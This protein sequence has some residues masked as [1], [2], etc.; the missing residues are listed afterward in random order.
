MSS[1]ICRS[2]CPLIKPIKKTAHAINYLESVKT[3]GCFDTMFSFWKHATYL[4]LV[5]VLVLVLLYK[6]CLLFPCIHFGKCI[7]LVVH[8]YMCISS[9]HEFAWYGLLNMIWY[10]WT[11]TCKKK[12][13]TSFC[14]FANPNHFATSLKSCSMC[15]NTFERPLCL[16]YMLSQFHE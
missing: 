8:F 7:F 6:D 14:W 13:C 15:T 11:Q 9:I 2:T 10:W 5:I 12:V 3:R 1:N 4:G 16:L